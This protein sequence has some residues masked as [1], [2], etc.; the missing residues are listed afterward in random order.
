MGK[1]QDFQPIEPEPRSFE[2]SRTIDVADDAAVHFW[3]DRLG[4]PPEE[5]VEAVKEVG[6][7]TTAVLLKLD[8]PRKASVAPPTMSPRS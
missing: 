6:S 8:A 1:Q 5:I 3:S 2:D 7:N 4:V